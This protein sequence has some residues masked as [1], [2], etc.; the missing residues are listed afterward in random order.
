M[1]TKALNRDVFEPSMSILKGEVLKQKLE[2]IS[3]STE[4]QGQDI[5]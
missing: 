2:I 3:F 4:A 1:M 5:S